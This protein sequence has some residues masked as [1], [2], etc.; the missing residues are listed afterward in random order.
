MKKTLF[1]GF[2]L[3]TGSLFLH[4]CDPWEDDSY[5]EGGNNNGGAGTL[6]LKEVKTTTANAEGLT[7]YIYD[8]NNR[9]KEVKNITDILDMQS[10]S[11]TTT[12]YT[13]NNISNS[14][15]KQ[16]M[17]GNLTMT[18]NMVTT[19]N[20]NNSATV[21][22]MIVD[23]EVTMTINYDA[24][25]S[26]PCGMVTSNV[27]MTGMGLPPTNYVLSHQYTDANC[28]YKEFID[29]TLS[30]TV[31]MDDKFSPYTNPESYSTGVYP[32]NATRIEDADGTIET[33]TYTYNA[34][35][36]PTKAVHTFTN[37][38]SQNYTEEFFYY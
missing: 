25:F 3:L 18:T 8:A 4:S 10:Y 7:T 19:V 28:S 37:S 20:G 27:S 22:E 15:T 30:T 14:V 36:Y 11:L 13:G 6:L 32:H 29:G 12:T 26:L 23:G 1:L 35:N 34:E 24:N 17:G 2:A 33:I 16:Y 9:V 21:I 5:H 38:E 31:T